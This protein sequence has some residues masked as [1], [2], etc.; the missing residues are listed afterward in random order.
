MKKHIELLSKIKTT[1]LDPNLPT[2]LGGTE[3]ELRQFVFQLKR[4]LVNMHTE[5]EV[6]NERIDKLEFEL[7]LQNG[8]VEPD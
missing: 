1:G 7:A 6:L 3:I 4:A 5:I 8:L 2:N